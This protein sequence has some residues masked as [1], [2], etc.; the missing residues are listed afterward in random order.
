MPL[1]GYAYFISLK[2]VYKNHAC[3][4]IGLFGSFTFSMNTIPLKGLKIF[5]QTKS[6]GA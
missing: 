5:D 3:Y 4:D 6:S 2:T 1:F